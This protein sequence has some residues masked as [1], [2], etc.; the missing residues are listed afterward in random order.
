MTTRIQ[1]LNT[2]IFVMYNIYTMK[3][4][5]ERRY[6]ISSVSGRDKARE[7]LRPAVFVAVHIRR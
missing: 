1:Y 4:T 5:I 2:P 6:N 7:S 3:E